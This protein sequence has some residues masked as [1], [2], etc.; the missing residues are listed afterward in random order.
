MR[1]AWGRQSPAANAP[2]GSAQ[3][4][5]PG[6]GGAP[7]PSRTGTTAARLLAA[8]SLRVHRRAW[9]AV[10]A[11]LVLTSFVLGG[12][13]LAIG[14]AA[15]GH[16][17]VERYA[18]APLVVA[19]DQ[20]TRFT[21]KP[22]GSEPNTEEVAL[23]ERV[24]L[25]RAAVGV[26]A[27]V[28]GVRKAVPDDSVPVGVAVAGGATRDGGGRETVAATGRPWPAAAL[29]PYELREGRAPR[30]AGEVV[31]GGGLARAA[32]ELASDG[33][34]SVAVPRSG[35]VRETEGWLRKGGGAPARA[36]GTGSLSLAGEA[37]SARRPGAKVTVSVDGQRRTYDVVGIASGPEAV[38]FT[39]AHARTLT[40]R[41]GSVATIGVL[42]E[43]GV[44]SAVLHDRIRRAL[45][46]ADVRD[47]AASHRAKD[48][49]TAPRILT[50]D[51][52]GAAEHLDA[53]PAR[54]GLLE[55]LGAVAA[56]LVMVSLLVVGSLIA[57]ALHQRRPELALLRAVGATPRQLR[58]AVGREVGYVAAR[59]AL[60]G[61][62]ASVPAFLAAW[63]PL[64]TPEGLQ[65]PT[66]P[67]LFVAPLLTAA[68]TLGLARLVALLATPR[69]DRHD[70][71]PSRARQR[72]G[73]GLLL[74]GTA[75]AGTAAA[76]SGETAAAAAGAAAVTMTAACALLGPWIAAAAMRLL[77]KPLRRRGPG[78]FLAA[79][80]CAANSRRLG[81]AITPIVLVTA[82][83]TVQLGADATQRHAG[84]EQAAAA[85][86]AD[87]EVAAPGGVDLDR[88]R[89]RTGVKA[90]TE[91]LPTTVV[92]ARR[93]AGEPRLDRL[94]ALGVTPSA[95]P[96]TLDPKVSSGHLAG[97]DKPGTVAVG[98]DRARSMGLD[99]GDT[100][101]LRLGDGQERK[102]RV[103][104][105]YERS[106]ALGDFL[107]AADQLRPYVSEPPTRALLATDTRPA[108]APAPVHL[109]PPD[110]S[111]TTAVAGTA[112][113]AIA[114]LTL[115][116]VLSTLALITTGRRPQLALLHRAGA[117]R[118]HLRALLR[119]EAALIA[120]TGL[121]LGAAVALLPLAA[122]SFATARALP[123]VSPAQAA[124]TVA[125][126]G[127]VTYAG[128]MPR[129]RTHGLGAGP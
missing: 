126:V 77:D 4:S 18:A 102:L 110:A 127:L 52:R 57:Q 92:L 49:R 122:F 120:A 44:G 22:W 98:R 112:V 48:D 29:A 124:L 19:G 65:L 123:Y 55:L 56:T 97:L 75:S 40:G 42:P 2:T 39:A 91:V 101:T 80:E 100:F 16:A 125:V 81:A 35:S 60:L 51:G 1:R 117:S 67:W 66:P 71:R 3:A 74:I 111:L 45:D 36:S 128:I 82:F 31:V 13:A 72:A 96:D 86:R 6:D 103:A 115:I 14:S 12:F 27:G 24:R 76:Q 26:V 90:A 34:G 53:A 50:G 37:S 25:P 20:S 30:A 5:R 107:F 119:T 21:A 28:E 68:L 64:P 88:L 121:A 69:S 89:A 113:A 94:P 61:S 58:A 62:V 43:P 47:S 73:V 95:L 7:A 63:Q 41:P 33:D 116:S 54:S 129:A 106:L 84:A 93:E 46:A 70:R 79:A 83:A 109:R 104:A 87:T 78:G 99:P 32:G 23:T 59:A 10:F 11:A 15:L 118:H 8:R 17:R 114:A 9:A 105:V 85:L 108:K 38:Y